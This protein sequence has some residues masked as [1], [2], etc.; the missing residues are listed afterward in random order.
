L[1]WGGAEKKAPGTGGKLPD[2]KKSSSLLAQKT[3]ELSPCPSHGQKKYLH[4]TAEAQSAPSP[5]PPKIKGD[6]PAKI[7]KKVIYIFRRRRENHF[8]TSAI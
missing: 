5:C 7:E 8:S 2:E 1:R 4:G 3:T 6:T